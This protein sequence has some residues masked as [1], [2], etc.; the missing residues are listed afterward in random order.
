MASQRVCAAPWVP[1]KEDSPLEACACPT[2]GTPL[3][4]PVE[5]EP[6][7]CPTAGTLRGGFSFRCKLQWA[8]IT[9]AQA[10]FAPASRP[11]R[12]STAADP[13]APACTR[14]QLRILWHLHV[15]GVSCG[16]FGTC[17]YAV[18]VVDPLAPACMRCR[19]R[20]HT[21]AYAPSQDASREAGGCRSMR[22]FSGCKRGSRRVQERGGRRT[23]K[24]S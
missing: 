1:F 5:E 3:W 10:S 6:R 7:M 13:L 16:S 2:V 11:C 24:R 4:K 12:P 14:C 17:M 18:S 20:I 23:A 8:C 15:R 9:A 19:F 22:A 21:C